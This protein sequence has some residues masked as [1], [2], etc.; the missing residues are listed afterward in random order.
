M[1]KKALPV[2]LDDVEREKL[3]KIAASWGVSLSSAIKRLIREYDGA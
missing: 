1:T 3:N 2:Y